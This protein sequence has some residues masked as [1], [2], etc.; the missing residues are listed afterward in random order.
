[1]FR[2]PRP[3]NHQNLYLRSSIEN[4]RICS[5]DVPVSRIVS[6]S[7]RSRTRGSSPS[8]VRFI[9]RGE[10]EW[11]SLG[12]Y[13]QWEILSSAGHASGGFVYERP[14]SLARALSGARAII[15]AR[16]IDCT[17]LSRARCA[18][19]NETSLGHSR[20][21]SSRDANRHRAFPLKLLL[22]RN[23]IR[24]PLIWSSSMPL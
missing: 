1:M 19:D 10:G 18:P 4:V 13:V 23:R 6:R 17:V 14:C 7:Y 16:I 21:K 15:L 11:R 8:D 12:R 20:V 5:H 24:H 9:D 2:Q 3:C 22:A